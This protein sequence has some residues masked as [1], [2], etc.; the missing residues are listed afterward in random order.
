MSTFGKREGYGSTD[1][2]PTHDSSAY[3]RQ[4]L[5]LFISNAFGQDVYVSIKRYDNDILPSRMYA[6]LRHRFK[7]V[8]RNVCDLLAAMAIDHRLYMQSPSYDFEPRP[9][10]QS[11]ASAPSL[12]SR[13]SVYLPM[14]RQVDGPAGG[15]VK[16]VVRVRGYL[17]RGQC[18]G[19]PRS[20]RD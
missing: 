7:D 1:I 13:H 10:P 6:P 20:R 19:H 15:N 16:V 11:T 4:K 5:R 18:A 9:D 17:P 8:L 3:I 14:A 2:I 12:R